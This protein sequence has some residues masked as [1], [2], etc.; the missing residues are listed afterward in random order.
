MAKKLQSVLGLL[1]SIVFLLTV[2]E[3]ELVAIGNNRVLGEKKV[4]KIKGN[5]SD[6]R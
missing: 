6:E 2:A 5:K 4:Q 3:R 1:M